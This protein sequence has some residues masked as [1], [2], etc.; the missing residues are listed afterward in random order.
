V[1]L[2]EDAAGVVQFVFDR[3]TTTFGQF[4]KPG[5]TPTAVALDNALTQL[6]LFAGGWPFSWPVAP[7][8]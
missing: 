2:F 1:S 4:G 5:I 8:P 7:E 6:F 3:P